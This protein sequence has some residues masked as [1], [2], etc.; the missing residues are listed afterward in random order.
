MRTMLLVS[1]AAVL[2][3]AGCG[4]K[5]DAAAKGGAAEAETPAAPVEVA[6]AEKTTIHRVVES[7]AILFSVN[8]ANI[9]A[10][11]S[12]PVKKFNVNRGDH[13][14]AGQVLGVLEDR[15][16]TASV[17]ENRQLVAQAQAAYTT[18]TGA[19]MPE[20]LIRA[21]ADL[22]SQQ[23]T[24]E[25]AT[26]VYESRVELQKQGA[27]A[28]KLVEDAKVT[29]VQAQAL[30]ENARQHLKSLETVGRTEQVKSLQA[31][32]DAAKARYEAAAAQLSYT[33]V[34]SPISGVVSDRPLYA[35]EMA[36]SGTAIIAVMD[37]SSVIARANIPVKEAGDVRAGRSATITGP[38]GE[39]QGRVTVVS[40][41]VDPNTTTVEVW[42]Q[43]A[44]PGEKLKPGTSVHVAI[45][46]QDIKNAIVV[47]ATALLTFDEGGEKVMVV[48]SDSL[49]HEHKVEVGVREGGKVQIL[50][51]V[52]EGDDVITVGGLG[53][54]DKA[55]VTTAKPDE[56]DDKKDDKADDKKD[57][58]K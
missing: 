45:S 13:V 27:L 53:L 26:K 6:K 30:L 36:Q 22:K 28:Q 17:A 40:P 4:G 41:A 19:Q 29:Q 49:A 32:L 1:A 31:Q 52:A 21:Q 39:L 56:K 12:A 47:P 51:G 42:I 37:I 2:V 35:G 18:A 8:Q 14:K 43:A 7:E 50:S 11:I 55:K 3:L 25:A 44:N 5:K 10:K 23:Q 16:L 38:G 15:D 24:V 54:D 58:K 46:A 57:E 9:T 48:G 34:R 33:E 20:D